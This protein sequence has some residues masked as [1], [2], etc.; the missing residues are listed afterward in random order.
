MS[1]LREKH[2]KFIEHLP[3]TVQEITIE[4]E[5]AFDLTGIDLARLR[6]A[7]RRFL[8][9]NRAVIRHTVTVDYSGGEEGIEEYRLIQ[10]PVA[11]DI[12]DAFRLA[13]DLGDRLHLEED[14]SESMRKYCTRSQSHGSKFVSI[15]PTLPLP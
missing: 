4:L 5:H 8:Q 10:R 6:D 13:L 14:V 12:R 9:L 3:D 11:E 7:F 2:I 1:R 15:L